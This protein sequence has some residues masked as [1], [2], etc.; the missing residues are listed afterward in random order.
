MPCSL[1]GMRRSLSDRFES[2]ED[3]QSFLGARPTSEFFTRTVFIFW[4]K[5]IVALP[6]PETEIDQHSLPCRP[7]GKLRYRGWN[8]EFFRTNSKT[9]EFDLAKRFRAPKRLNLL[10]LVIEMSSERMVRVVSFRD[11]IGDCEL[12]LMNPKPLGF[13][14]GSKFSRAPRYNRMAAVWP[15]T[16]SP[17][18]KNGGANGACALSCFLRKFSSNVSACGSFAMSM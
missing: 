10:L 5:H 16:S 7:Q 4:E 6:R 11:Q 13:L 3:A 1:K 17:S 2:A 14:R 18:T 9:S 12:N 15:I 8:P